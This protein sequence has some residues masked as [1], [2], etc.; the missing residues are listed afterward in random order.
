M[1][2]LPEKITSILQLPRPTNVWNIVGLRETG[3]LQETKQVT[4]LGPV[5][6]IPS[7]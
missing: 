5:N 3:Q 1:R 4:Q 6:S 2:E 7:F